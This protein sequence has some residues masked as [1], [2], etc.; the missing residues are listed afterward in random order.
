MYGMSLESGIVS[1]GSVRPFSMKGV[2]S[3]IGETRINYTQ[4]GIY[5]GIDKDNARVC[6]ERVIKELS[7]KVRAVYFCI[8]KWRCNEINRVKV[9][10][11]IFLISVNSWSV[12]ISLLSLLMNSSSLKLWY[13]F[14]E[15]RLS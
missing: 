1:S 5:A 13:F 3:G 4:I 6:I 15:K 12:V 2:I 7:E 8:W 10:K 11:W 9:L 14:L